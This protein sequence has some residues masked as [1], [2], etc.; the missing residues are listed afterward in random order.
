VIAA[1]LKLFQNCTRPKQRV[2]F[3]DHVI[4]APLKPGSI[5]G[6]ILDTSLVSAIT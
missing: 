4:A 3:R 1:P 2:R 5:D 6:S